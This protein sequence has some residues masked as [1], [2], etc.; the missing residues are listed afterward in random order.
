MHCGD[1]GQIVVVMEGREAFELAMRLAFLPHKY[2]KRSAATHY[3]IE[4]KPAFGGTNNLPTMLFETQHPRLI[5]YWIEDKT[6]LELPF[7]MDVDDAINFAWGWLQ[8]QDYGE[9]PDHDGSDG[10][11]FAVY[12]EAWGHVGNSHA[13]I[14]AVSPQW[15]WYGK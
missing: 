6:A 11:G 9:E 1:N 15:S 3:K 13:A 8:K 7:P 14:C 2:P 12:N 10:K 4:K 5:F